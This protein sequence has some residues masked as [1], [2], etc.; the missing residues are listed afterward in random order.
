MCALMVAAAA[1]AAVDTR[2]SKECYFA[3]LGHPIYILLLMILRSKPKQQE[4]VR[5]EEDKQTT[6]KLDPTQSPPTSHI[7]S[8]CCG[9]A[10]WLS[11]DDDEESRNSLVVV[12]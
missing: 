4:Q 2:G 12:R 5:E 1:A 11:G 10:G 3:N 6:H 8:V 9:S 7:P